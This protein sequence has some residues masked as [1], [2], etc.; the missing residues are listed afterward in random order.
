MIGGAIDGKGPGLTADVPVIIVNLRA[1][2]VVPLG[3]EQ[4]N[5]GFIGSGR[6][7]NVVN[8]NRTDRI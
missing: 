2:L 3:Q 4:R 8:H 6:E 7:W 5:E 1:I